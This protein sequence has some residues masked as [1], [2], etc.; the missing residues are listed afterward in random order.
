MPRKQSPR[1]LD[2]ARAGNAQIV[3]MVEQPWGRPGLPLAK[4]RAIP[5]Q[6]VELQ[7]LADGLNDTGVKNPRAT[8]IAWR[9]AR[10]IMDELDEAGF[11]GKLDV[12]LPP[13]P[14][15]R[16]NSVAKT[17]FS[18]PYLGLADEEDKGI[19]NTGPFW[20]QQSEGTDR[21]DW[22]VW[23]GVSYTNRGG[24]VVHLLQTYF[25]SIARDR[26]K[27][28]RQCARWFVDFTKNKGQLGCSQTCTS[29]W[30]NRSH[31]REA[32]HA[33]Y[34]GGTRRRNG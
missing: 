22:L 6:L 27:R 7:A 23:G 32:N 8:E 26:L 19:L 11:V 31:R 33:Q 28:C 16:F 29:K 14:A 12:L 13:G 30:W 1:T 20:V 10:T 18:H 25:R 34:S 4:D 15:R 17:T 24:Y 21:R 5:G 9:T 2:V 3:R